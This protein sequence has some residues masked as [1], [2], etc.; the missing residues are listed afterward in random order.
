MLSLSQQLTTSTRQDFVHLF[1]VVA[2][3]RKL[4]SAN[5]IDTSHCFGKELLLA[6]LALA[7]D[8]VFIGS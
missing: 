2:I 8:N 6:N 1:A 4:F 5:G 3:R 7:T